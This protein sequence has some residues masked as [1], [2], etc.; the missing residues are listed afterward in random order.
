MH[1]QRQHPDTPLPTHI[2][3]RIGEEQQNKYKVVQINSKIKDCPVPES[4]FGRNAETPTTNQQESTP[5]N[6]TEPTTH[7]ERSTATSTPEKTPTTQSTGES[8]PQMNN[9]AEISAKS[10]PELFNLIA[11]TITDFQ[12]KNN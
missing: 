2:S 11:K 8:Q 3:M 5:V 1:Y 9:L 12:N 6:N 7:S 10:N 4:T